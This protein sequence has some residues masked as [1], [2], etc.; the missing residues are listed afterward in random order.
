MISAVVVHWFRVLFLTSE[1]SLT[2][3][4]FILIFYPS[5]DIVTVKP[6]NNH[7]LC[8]KEKYPCTAN[9]LSDWL[10]FD[11]TSKSVVHFNARK[12]F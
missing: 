3:M 9:L 7:L 11:R 1:Y 12:E 8:K 6:I 4:R 5:C 10:G 2:L